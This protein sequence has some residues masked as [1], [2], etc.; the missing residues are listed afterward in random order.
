MISLKSLETKIKPIITELGY[1][2][3]SIKWG[4]EDGK[5]ALIIKIDKENGI[6]VEDC[7][8]VSRKIDSII[9]ESD[10]G[11]NFVLIVSSKGINGN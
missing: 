8:K 10:L 4:S 6:S 3:V 1:Q 2:L 7:A 9:D 5:K 11:E